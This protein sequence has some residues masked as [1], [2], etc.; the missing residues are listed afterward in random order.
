VRGVCQCAVLLP[1]CAASRAQLRPGCCSSTAS[2]VCL[3]A[4]AAA[5][6]APERTRRH[7]LC[8]PRRW[9]VHASCCRSDPQL[10]QR[11]KQSRLPARARA[12]ESQHPNRA[13]DCHSTPPAGTTRSCRSDRSTAS[14]CASGWCSGRWCPFRTPACAPRSTRPTEWAT[15]KTSSCPGGHRLGSRSALA[16]VL[17]PLAAL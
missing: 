13:T 12:S 9:S 15:S 8:E 11:Q 10:P 5:T 6:N 14:S 4:N 17:R 2:A 1:Q 16:L 3:T 7:N